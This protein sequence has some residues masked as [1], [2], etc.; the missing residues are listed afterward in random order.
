MRL[1]VRGVQATPT[2]VR[3][4]AKK[5]RTPRI[6][7]GPPELNLTVDMT[8]S[9]RHADSPVSM[10]AS[11]EDGASSAANR[12]ESNPCTARNTD[13]GSALMDGQYA[14]PTQQMTGDTE[15]RLT[16]TIS[17]LQTSQ[18]PSVPDQMVHRMPPSSTTTDPLPRSPCDTNPEQLP[19]NTNQFHNAKDQAKMNDTGP[20]FTDAAASG[21][22]KKN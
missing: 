17:K 2:V 3:T 7:R 5:E 11:P 16:E 20:S 9:V 6:L 22:V 12:R 4:Q 10:D 14:E 8:A 1:A 15:W 18:L 21:R 13:N 19:S